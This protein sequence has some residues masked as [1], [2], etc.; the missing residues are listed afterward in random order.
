MS[1]REHNVLDGSL[2]QSGGGLAIFNYELTNAIQNHVVQ[3]HVRFPTRFLPPL[4]IAL[5]VSIDTYRLR[6]PNTRGFESDY[7]AVDG[8][9]LTHPAKA[10][11][12]V[13]GCYFIAQGDTCVH[14]EW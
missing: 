14:F 13:T 10:F 1:V 4:D 11:E 6:Q 8:Q 2:A 12:V 5:G 7:I 3:S 9:I